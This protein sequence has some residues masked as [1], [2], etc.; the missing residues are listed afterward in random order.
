[1]AAINHRRRNMGVFVHECLLHN[2][3]AGFLDA[4]LLKSDFTSL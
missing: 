3:L 4:V 2:M 1:M